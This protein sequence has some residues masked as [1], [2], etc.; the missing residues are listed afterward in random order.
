MGDTSQRTQPNIIFIS[1][2]ELRFPV[3]FPEGVTTAEQFLA[4][5]MPFTHRLLWQDGVKFTDHQI[6]SCACTPSRGTIVTGLYSQQTYLM[7]TR[8][9]PGAMMQSPVT[10]QPALQTGFPTYGKLLKELG[11]D[12]PYIG[13]WHLSNSAADPNSP[14][15]QHYLDDYGFQAVTI[16]DPVGFPGQG[17]GATPPLPSIR[18]GQPQSDASIAAQAVSWLYNRAQSGNAT[19]FCLSVG[20][21]NPH[22]Q[23][24]FWAGIDGNRF[25]ALYAQSPQPPGVIYNC[26]IVGEAFP[27]QYG[28]HLPGN[29]E[30]A[31][32]LQETSPKLHRVAREFYAYYMAGDI[33][34]DPTQVDFTLQPSPSATDPNDP[35]QPALKAV[36]PF[37]YWTKALDTYTLLMTMVD[38]QIAQ[39]VMNIPESLRDNTIIV[40]TSDHGDYAGSHGLVGK[41][42]ALYKESLHVPLMV[43]D[44]TGSVVNAPA[45]E[46]SQLTSHVDVLGL[47]VSLA[48]GETGWMAD[49]PYAAL[50]SARAR[51][52]DML[53]D[54]AA[55]G[56]RVA[57]HA[58]D[59]PINIG[60]N[61]LNAPPHVVGAITADGKLGT[62][63]FWNP[64]QDAAM[65]LPSGLEVEY[66]D[67][68][69]A[70]GRAET[71]ST[72]D[73]PDAQVL[74]QAL[75][76]NL[77]PNELQ[78]P[79]PAAYADAQATAL[80]QYWQYV[81][82]ADKQTLIAGLTG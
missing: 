67:Y 32:R 49:G 5:F 78:A 47:L 13:K 20:L 54:P 41:A 77:I 17:A 70:A 10:P 29:W 62:Y 35:T 31:A 45:V 51:L 28:Y 56:R 46:R 53:R 65:P 23:M 11:Y 73:H 14:I 4:K 2:D 75:L 81:K 57:L 18:L 27:P 59:E 43:R 36:A 72:P 71:H 8:A 33:A 30:S 42:F 19:P 38:Q 25:N 6:A 37:S 15:A 63:A 7:A 16:P 82:N 80:D 66:Y 68:A 60:W 22:D 69:T 79:L 61:Y 1:C 24:F 26:T 50:Y 58:T 44:Y 34:D 64:K 3:H 12:T 9:L 55:P 76:N 21:V 39:V 48:K 52:Y 40:F 74:L